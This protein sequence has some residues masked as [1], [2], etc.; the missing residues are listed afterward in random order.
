[1]LV[2]PHPGEGLRIAPDSTDSRSRAPTG[3]PPGGREARRWGKFH[4]S[5]GQPRSFAHLATSTFPPLAMHVNVFAYHG[6]PRSFAHAS[7][8]IDPTKFG[9]L[10]SSLLTAATSLTSPTGESNTTSRIFRFTVASIARSPSSSRESTCA[11]KTS[12]AS[13]ASRSRSGSRAA[14]R[15]SRPRAAS[16]SASRRVVVVTSSSSSDGGSSTRA[17]LRPADGDAPTARRARTPPRARRS[18]RRERAL[19][20]ERVA[21]RLQRVDPRDD[22]VVR[23]SDGVSASRGRAIARAP[24]APRRRHLVGTTR[25]RR[26]E[27]ADDDDD[28]ATG[29]AV[30]C[31]TDRTRTR[32]G[33][34]LFS[35]PARARVNPTCPVGAA[36]RRVQRLL[37]PSFV[38]RPRAPGTDGTSAP[39]LAPRPST[40]PRRPPSRR[41]RRAKDARETARRRAAGVGQRLREGGNLN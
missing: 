23:R 33:G 9:T 25:A 1:M 18:L 2:P 36:R 16:C 34:A 13:A 20:R 28:D 24:S 4:S 30:R 11:T 35:V 29:A 27:P 38:T 31:A 21:L 8:P 15:S 26:E 40:R 37:L 7:L 6:H 17:R 19:R 12:R 22:R 39:R 3:A 41:R 10:A 5:H 32:R 14:S